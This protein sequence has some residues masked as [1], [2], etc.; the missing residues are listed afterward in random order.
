MKLSIILITLLNSVA[1]TPDLCAVP[2]LDVDGDPITDSIGQTLSRY[3]QWTGPG[4]PVLDREVC[5]VLDEDSAAC[6]LPDATG[7]C[8]FGVK[9]Y[10]TY[11]AI[12]SVGVVTCYQPFP[13]ACRAGF[14]V[15]RPEIPP[16]TMESGLLCC[17]SGGA[18]FS[19]NHKQIEDCEATGTLTWCSDGV[20]DQDGTVICFD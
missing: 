1:N 3:C 2:Y 13:D 18:C 19:I 10:C 14:C 20:T 17:N 6:G 7:G 12:T 9:R 5:C 16:P 15:E 8:S 11:G 4:V